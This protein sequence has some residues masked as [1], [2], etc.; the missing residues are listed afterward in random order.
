[1][2]VRG[3][4]TRSNLRPRGTR[5]R[6]QQR[7]A[8]QGHQRPGHAVIHRVVADLRADVACGHAGQ[9]PVLRVADRNDERLKPAVFPARD[10]ARE[11]ERMV[12]RVP[13][14]ARPPLGSVERR[15]VHLNL[16]SFR[17]ERGGRLQPAHVG[18]VRELGLGVAA[19]HLRAGHA[20][21]GAAALRAA[22]RVV[23]RASPDCMRGIQCSSCSAESIARQCGTNIEKW[24]SSGI[25]CGVGRGVSTPAWPGRRDVVA[26]PAWP[27][28]WEA[29]ASPE[30][31][32]AR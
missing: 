18:A 21:S 6:Q 4:R 23:A 26:M 15:R 5:S 25:T 22:A 11:D 16:V 2:F 10:E 1:M 8:R 29:L 24:T 7:E 19:D 13:K 3:T 30:T 17:Y 20:A 28:R 31:R 32:R 27:G 14:P 9:R 12:G